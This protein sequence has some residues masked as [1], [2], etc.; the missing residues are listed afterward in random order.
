MASNR[1][2]HI[3]RAPGALPLIGHT[4][5][6]GRDPLGFLRTLRKSGELVRIDLGTLPIYVA[7][8][9]RVIHQVTVEHS[10]SFEKGRLYDRV[11][12]LFGNG[13]ATA[14]GDVH[15]THRRLIQPMFHR[16]RIEG[17]AAVMSRRAVALADSWT[18]GQQVDIGHVMSE[19]TI[20]TLAETMFSTDMGRPAVDAAL[21]DLP[22][23]LRT[24]LLRAA[25]PKVLE[26]LPIRIHRDFDRAGANLR[27]IIDDVV[28]TTRQHRDEGGTDLVSLLLDARDEAT[29]LGLTDEE[30]RDELVTFLF[31]GTDTTACVLGW[32]VSEIAR[33]P[34]VERDV[35]AEIDEVTGDRPV[36]V[37]DIPRLGTIRRVLDE[38]VRLHGATLL[39]R[40]TTEPVELAGHPLPAGVE[41]AFSLYAMHRDPALYP[42]PDR[43]D[44]DRWLPERRAAVPRE[45][46]VPF[47]AGNRKCIGDTFAWTEA[48]IALAT[49]LARWRLRPVPGSAEPRESAAVMAYPDRVPMIV[50]ARRP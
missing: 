22:V 4:I 19:Y 30:V 12:T 40:R 41:V 3:P 27:R 37:D 33:H 29:G 20:E 7:T 2:Q 48:T 23:I 42:D 50:E 46:F 13:L 24:M 8:S 36:T 21:R 14:N 16:S 10:R 25:S 17:Y 45:A 31:A 6:L 9:A 34:R 18:D 1:L 43:F 15:R 28:V 5:R 44:P 38:S 32:A 11:R 35:L 47:G 39:M 26:R 49:L